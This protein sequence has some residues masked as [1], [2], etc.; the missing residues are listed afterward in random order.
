MSHQPARLA[1]CLLAL[2]GVLALA[3]AGGGQAVAAEATVGLG[4]AT[5]FAVLAGS[6]VTNTGPSVIS[7]DLGVSPGSAVTGFTGPPAGTVVNGTIYA[8][9]AAEPAQAQSDLTLAYDDAASRPTSVTVTADLGG[10]VL[11]PG[12]YT[13]Q[14]GILGLTGTVTLD[15]AGD[16]GAVFIFQA[17][18]T[19]T[20]ASASTVSLI[21]GGNPCNVFWQVGSSATLGTN[22]VFVGTILALTSI[23]ATTGASVEGRLLARNGAVTLDSNTVTLP[24]CEP[25]PGATTTTTTVAPTTSTLEPTTSTVPSTTSTAP[26]TS[27]T[28]STTTSTT[29]PGGTTSTLAG[30][31]GPAGGGAT[32]GSSG[33]TATSPGGSLARTGSQVKPLTVGGVLALVLGGL[34]LLASRRP[35][36]GNHFPH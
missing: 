24:V 4:T 3:A 36:A 29:V 5:S 8:A 17:G 30:A 21:N 19:L 18:S 12:V 7:G 16:P 2:G 11:A 1:G 28:L 27:S 9:P 26:T 14:D 32:G 31:G 35:R 33:A 13:G 10:Q 22:S 6:T 20:T 25:R 23:T 34:M 15:A